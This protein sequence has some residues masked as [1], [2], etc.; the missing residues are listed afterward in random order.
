MSGSE[1]ARR[2]AG[3]SPRKVFLRTPSEEAAAPPSGRAPAA[4]TDDRAS[5]PKR[6]NG[7]GTPPPT[8]CKTIPPQSFRGRLPKGAPPELRGSIGQRSLLALGCS[9]AGGWPPQSRGSM[10]RAP[11][12]LSEAPPQGGAPPPISRLGGVRV[13]VVPHP[14][15]FPRW[16]GTPLGFRGSIG[17][18]LTPLSEL[19]R[20][21]GPPRSRGSIGSGAP[22][23]IAD[24]PSLGGGPP[25]DHEVQLGRPSLRL[26]RVPASGGYPLGFR[27]SIGQPRRP[28]SETARPAGPERGRR[29]GGSLS[30]RRP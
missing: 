6:R 19:C 1:S 18:A 22:L 15:P 4:A 16:G 28:P 10:G 17:Q 14:C 23:P 13:G 27:G 11:L 30:D 21:V 3:S 2:H 24:A 5:G 8:F 9:T 12:S 20:G 7:G 29:C 25:P 26:A